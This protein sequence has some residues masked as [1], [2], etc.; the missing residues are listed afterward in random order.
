MQSVIE[1]D[2]NTSHR[3]QNKLL[4]GKIDLGSKNKIFALFALWNL[5][6]VCQ[7]STSISILK[8]ISS[9]KLFTLKKTCIWC[10]QKYRKLWT[11]SLNIFIYWN[12]SGLLGSTSISTSRDIIFKSLYMQTVK[13]WECSCRALKCIYCIVL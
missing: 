3:L 8:N 4:L 9:Y 7:Y 13:A 5:H 11:M 1:S 2:Q 6:S 12:T 10:V